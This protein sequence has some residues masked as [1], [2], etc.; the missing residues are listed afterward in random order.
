MSEILK[1]RTYC[2]YFTGN[3]QGSSRSVDDG[4]EE[5]E[6]LS[7][8]S[9]DIQEQPKPISIIGASMNSFHSL[10]IRKAPKEALRSLND[11]PPLQANVGVLPPQTVTIGRGFSNEQKLGILPQQR[12]FCSRPRNSPFGTTSPWSSN[13]PAPHSV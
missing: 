5:G 6:I 13:F 11:T 4:E 10:F 8:G 12:A 3:E 9:D 2:S 1:A 7:D